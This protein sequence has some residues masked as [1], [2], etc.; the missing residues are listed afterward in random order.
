MALKLIAFGFAAGWAALAKLTQPRR[1]HEPRAVRFLPLERERARIPEEH[2]D[3]RR[4]L[5][6]PDFGDDGP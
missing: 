5:A 1:L 2:K 3:W 4:G 6:I